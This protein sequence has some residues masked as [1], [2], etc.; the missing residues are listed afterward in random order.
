MWREGSQPHLRRVFAGEAFVDMDAAR[1]VRGT[2]AA[3]ACRVE[4][5]EAKVH[6]VISRDGNKL[7]H[8]SA[9]LETAA[10]PWICTDEIQPDGIQS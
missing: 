7:R 9:H 10:V 8:L 2:R 3:G 5:G 6:G 1:V 4:A